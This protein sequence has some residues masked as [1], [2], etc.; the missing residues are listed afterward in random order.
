MVSCLNSALQ[1]W[2]GV[3]GKNVHYVMKGTNCFTEMYSAIAADVPMEADDS[4]KKNMVVLDEFITQAK[5]VC[6]SHCSMLDNIVNCM[7]GGEVTLCE[8]HTS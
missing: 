4:T 7:W 1:E 8:L 2:C 6:I 5:K 3:R